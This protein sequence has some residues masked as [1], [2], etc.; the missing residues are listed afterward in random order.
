LDTH[1]LQNQTSAAQY[2]EISFDVP[3]N[4]AAICRLAFKINT[5]P[6]KNAPRALSG[7]APYIISISRLDPGINKDTDTWNRHPKVT[8][9]YASF[10]LTQEG[11]VSE[12][13]SKWFECPKGQIAQFVLHPG[14]TRDISYYW[15]ELDYKS[16]EGGPHGVVLEMHT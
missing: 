4:E 12:V 2:T 11:T 16:E 10:S 14:S 8:E 7:E 9:Y 6:A 1:G 3:S 13:Y 15:F 5:S